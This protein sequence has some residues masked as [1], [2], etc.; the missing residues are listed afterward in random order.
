MIDL[1]VRTKHCSHFLPDIT[2][3]L[4]VSGYGLIN[5]V[6]GILGEDLRDTPL[7]QKFNVYVQTKFLVATQ[8]NHH[9][10]EKSAQGLF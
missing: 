7:H 10:G 1:P 3:H 6:N 8:L 9:N 5:H 2:V 4:Y